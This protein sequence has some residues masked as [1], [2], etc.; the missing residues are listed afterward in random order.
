MNRTVGT[1]L[2]RLIASGIIARF[3]LNS[4]AMT[5]LI[6]GLLYQRYRDK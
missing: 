4:T 2:E 1:M 5:C 3:T 6:F